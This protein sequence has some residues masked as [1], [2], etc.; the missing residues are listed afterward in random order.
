MLRPRF[1]LVTGAVLIA[2][3][4][5]WRLTIKI[6]EVS[7]EKELIFE[8]PKGI[9]FGALMQRIGI[10]PN[11]INSIFESAQGK[12][13][14]SKIVSG[15]NLAL[16]SSTIGG[17]L[18]K[19]VYEIDTESELI[20]EEK[21]GGWEAAV[22]AID[23]E[24]EEKETTGVI[25]SSLYQTI[26]ASGSDERLAL[27]LAE[28]FAWQID[29][30]ADIREGDSFKAIYE[31]R[32]RDGIYVMPGKILAAKF[33]N[34]G[35]EFQGYYF[36]GSEK[37]KA[38]HY[39]EKGN[40]VQKVFLKAP[41]QY[42][43]ISSGYS[44]AR[45]NPITRQISPHRG[46]D[47]AAPAGTPAV[48]VGDGT[49]IQAGWNGY[50]GLSV[51]VRHNETYT[52]RYG[53]FQS[54]AKGVKVGAKVTQGQVVGYVGSTGLATGP[55][56]HYE[57]HKFGSLVNPFKIEIPPGDPVVAEDRAEFEKTV[58]LFTKRLVK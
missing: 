28:M 37:T 54:L 20:A 6:P 10:D 56:L 2:T 3:L 11:E 55:H 36:A 48:S 17:D 38:G 57:I 39:D 4:L 46:I 5:F 27:A 21:E 42:K 53:H 15:H 43:Y 34:D 19:L 44:L 29:F 51:T 8:V 18:K 32:Y 30:A 49:V 9:T 33:V 25:E 50:Y 35:V 41:L 24:V 23:Y 26:V 16:I 47:Y 14:L 13:D 1:I 22:E 45:V 58:G 12:Y 31:E 52:S 7:K 40:S